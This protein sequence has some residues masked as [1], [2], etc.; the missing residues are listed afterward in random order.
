MAYLSSITD[1]VEIDPLARDR[2]E[3][4]Q[5]AEDFLEYVEDRIK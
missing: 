4:C 5:N 2:V 1:P 3:F